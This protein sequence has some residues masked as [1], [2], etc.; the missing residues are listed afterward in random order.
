[1]FFK[2]RF[3]IV[4]L[5]FSF[6]LTV[7]FAIRTVLL[8]KSL[9]MLD[10]TVW[11]LIKIYG[12]GLFYDAVTMLYFA[13]P[14]VLYLI[15]VPDKIYRSAIHKPVV[16]LIAFFT[17]YLLIFAGIA[18]Y[19][20]FDEFNV[21]FNF[22]AID[23]LIYTT[24]V[25]KN[26]RESYPVTM[27]LSVIAI[28]SLMLFLY[29]RKWLDRL[30]K[31]ESSLK[32]RVKKGIIFVIL[33]FLPLA[34]VDLSLSAISANTYANELSGNGIY[35][36]FAAFRHNQIDYDQ[37]YATMDTGALFRK[38]KGLLGERNSAFATNDALDISRNI[39]N[40]GEEKRLN[41]AVIV[42]ESLSAEFL[43]TFGNGEHLT[44]KLDALAQK[45]LLFTNMY[46]TGTRTVRGLEAVTLSIP[47]TPGT[48]VIKRPHNEDMFSWG[49]IMREKGYDTK[50]IYGGYGYF[51]NMN[52]FFSHNGFTAVDRT[53]FSK[54]ETIFEN[55]WGVSD[56]DLFNK[57]IA[58][59]NKSYK[60]STPFFAVIM[61]TSN[62]RPY[63]YPEGRID[64]PSHTGRNGA[65][66]YTDYAIGKFIND[67]KKEPWFNDTIFIIV[68]DH[69]A[70]SA[71]KTKLPVE[72]YRIPL[73]IYSPAHIK[74]MRIDKLASQIDIAPTVLGLLNFSYRSSFF[75]KDILRISPDQ[76]R[77]F[78]STYEKLGYIKDN[79]LEIL[80]VK[81]TAGLYRFDRFTGKVE[82]LPDSK[83]MLDEAVSY[84][85]G[86]SYLYKHKLNRWTG[87]DQRSGRLT[88]RTNAR[89]SVSPGR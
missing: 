87:D 32:Q 13:L 83:D 54:G 79:R 26:I 19:F 88:G 22:I 25:V 81:K 76:G 40:T 78:I 20:F 56:E 27:L 9:P 5:F 57:S 3:G 33:P 66:K 37:F 46:A 80:D 44:P 73:L 75:G 49:F 84:Y 50:F 1:M 14:F 59:F 58:V 38:L 61:T 23:Y 70:S 2:S 67:A 62:H 64:I 30:L 31:I 24:E 36:L 11:L 29:S 16:Y 43:G 17:I 51:D 6:F 69:C 18:E 77:A 39:K 15:L 53:D 48:S 72:K 42:V 63:T 8:V 89:P 82:E 12:T 52:Y 65:V 4:Y 34:S 10:P 45:G 7:S 35:D 86:S 55:A 68:A 47:P 60:N 21:R 74:P 85:Q 41:V 28:L 71:G